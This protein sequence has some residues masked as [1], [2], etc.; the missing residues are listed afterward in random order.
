MPSYRSLRD[1]Y[2]GDLEH[3][4]EIKVSLIVSRDGGWDADLIHAQ[5]HLC[6]ASEIL[7]IK[8][9][10][11][12]HKNVWIWLE[13]RGEKFSIQSTYKFFNN[14]QNEERGKTSLAYGYN[15]LWKKL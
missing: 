6:I 13:D 9:G 1:F 14:L 4:Q 7:K 12:K 10:S 15:S 3:L 2:S 11:P 5:V 8:L